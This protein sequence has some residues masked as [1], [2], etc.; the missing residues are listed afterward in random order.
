MKSI[1]AEIQLLVN[2]HLSGT[3]T[4]SQQERLMELL[5]SN[6]EARECFLEFVD[7]N[8]ELLWSLHSCRG[9]RMVTT[10]RPG[11]EE[12]VRES[13]SNHASPA[14]QGS[15][16]P[17]GR[18]FRSIP[19][20]WGLFMGSAAAVLLLVL[21]TAFIPWRPPAAKN[22]TS[23]EALQA[24]HLT[25]PQSLQLDSGVTKLVLPEV[26]YV[27]LE[28]PGE[29]TLLGKKRARLTSGRIKMRVSEDSGRGFVIETPY[30]EIKDLGTEFGV[31]LTE[32]G[33][34]GLVVFEGTVDLLVGKSGQNPSV[35]NNKAQR[36]IGGEGVVFNDRG[37]FD[38]IGSIS[39]GHGGTFKRNNEH[40]GEGSPALIVGVSDNLRTSE[41]KKLYEIGTG[42]FKE[43]AL[44][45]VDRPNHDW[46]GV[47]RRGL[48]RYLLGA[49]YVKT[50]NDDK[51][52]DHIAISVT[53]AKPARLFVFFDD[54]VPTPAWLKTGFRNTGDKIGHDAGTY[55]LRS[56]Q[57]ANF[58]RGK[59][60]GKSIDSVFTVWEK[61]C[62]SPGTVVLGSEI[63]E[64]SSA[65][66]GIAAL[67]LENPKKSSSQLGIGII[68]LANY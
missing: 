46:S 13:S 21:G 62:E 59:G 8:A 30:G 40:S 23:H 58:T 12:L 60:P 4:E 55:R 25:V 3:L 38:R 27:L 67:P 65:M 32:Q 49:D 20:A 17:G 43:D 24:T 31:D 5:R 15:G 2:G 28:G 48:P 16:M 63:A 26:G 33:K 56:G 34:A 10:G 9:D 14:V 51:A 19:N 52:L 36:L 35:E 7:L 22:E 54:R 44:A 41:T 6:A 39:T 18:H 47:D 50:F 61:K 53:L 37:Q 1:T 11:I 42:G 45:Y 64:K 68:P 29:F 57:Y 66:Y